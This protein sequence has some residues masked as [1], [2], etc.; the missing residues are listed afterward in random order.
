MTIKT[1]FGI[2]TG[3]D[4]I[5]HDHVNYIL[6]EL[7]FNMTLQCQLLLSSLFSHPMD[8]VVNA[9]HY[10]IEPSVRLLK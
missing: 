9:L 8:K 3:T 4:L 1:Q 6:N 7:K 10:C 5:P 2:H